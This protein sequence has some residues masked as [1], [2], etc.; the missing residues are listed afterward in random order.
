MARILV[1]DD[2]RSVRIT[3]QAFLQ[4]DGHDVVVAEDAGSALSLL[5]AEDFDVVVTDIV[6]PRMTG[7]DLLEAIGAVSPDV[8]VIIITGEP[9]VDTASAAVR[10]GAFDYMSKPVTKETIQKR[11]RNAVKVK[12][13]DDERRRLEEE[14]RRH[15]EELEQLVQERTGA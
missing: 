13:L 10:E 8:Q 3:L 9:T 2:E 4:E 7:V 14:N 6:M 12:Y 11:V 5:E 1:V 15:R